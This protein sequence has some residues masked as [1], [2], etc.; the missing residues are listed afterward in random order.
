M[1]VRSIRGC[2]TAL[3][4]ACVWSLSA[5][6]PARD[7]AAAK[8][9]LKAYQPLVGGWR[10]VG[11]P[12]RGSNVGAWRETVEIRWDFPQG[13]VGLVWTAKE[14]P[15]WKTAWFTALTAEQY[16]FRTTH[17]DDSTRTYRGKRD[18]DRLV[19]ET[20]AEGATEVHRATFTFLGDNRWTLLLERRA[21]AQSFYQRIG[22]IGYQREGTKLAAI[23]G[24]G[25]ECVVT[26][27]LGTIAVMHAGKTYYVCCTGCRDAF[28]ADP[29]GT[30]AD[31]AKRKAAK[32]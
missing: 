25:P 32:K 28:N 31:W 22:E 7:L 20:A 8:G 1:P 15:H 4:V 5:A 10:G 12:K 9:W 11:Q 16:E 3:L 26:G 14:S 2:C 13:D 30:L 18:G 21:V 24:N 19:M 29:E 23:D 27:G 6:D 17:A